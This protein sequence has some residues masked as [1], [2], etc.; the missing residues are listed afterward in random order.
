MAAFIGWGVWCWVRQGHDALASLS[1]VAWPWGSWHSEQEGS[2]APLGHLRLSTELLGC[3]IP[4]LG[5]NPGAAG[6]CW[7][8]GGTG[9]GAQDIS[10]SLSELWCPLSKPAACQTLP[11]LWESVVGLL[12]G[13]RHLGS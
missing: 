1:T 8:H 5:R 6:S 3:L 13:E 10:V 4:L 11:C 12:W 9:R 2:S 7:P